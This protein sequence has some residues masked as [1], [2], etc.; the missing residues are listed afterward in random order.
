M[1]RSV[2]L[3]LYL[4]TN[5]GALEFDDFV[6]I[7]RASIDGGV[8]IVQLREKE[9]SARETISI[10]KRLLSVLKP[11][12]IPLII[13]DRV[14]VAHAIGADG[15]HLG[16]SDL[17]PA[18][19]IRVAEARAILG[20]EAIIGLSVESLEQAL[21]A[22]V[23]E[24]DYLAAS[25]LFPTKTKADCGEPWGLDGLKQLCAISNHPVIA[26]GG[27]DETNAKQIIDCGA[28]GVAV[29]SAIFNAPCPKTAALTMMNSMK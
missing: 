3:S 9:A 26:I 17:V 12:G 22:N 14:G 13:N 15:V 25:P 16:Q 2:D 28:V 10:G 19:S 24:V 6:N 8:K 7:I 20:K 23:E 18:G 11:L 29:V 21:A 1:K 27:I 4:V 5:R